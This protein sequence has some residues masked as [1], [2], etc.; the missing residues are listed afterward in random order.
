MT[1]DAV[2][3]SFTRRRELPLAICLLA[4]ACTQADGIGL[5]GAGA[6]DVAFRD[7]S[8]RIEMA[9]SA[10]VATP[11]NPVSDIS[12]SITTD[13][14]G[15]VYI[16]GTTDGALP[17]EDPVGLTDMFVRKYDPELD[18]LWT[19]Q[20]GTEFDDGTVTWMWAR[21][22][23]ATY[24]DLVYVSGSAP[25]GLGGMDAFLGA[26]DAVTGDEVW[27]RVFGS[28]AS[29]NALDI[30]ADEDGV[31]VLGW[32][33]QGAALPGPCLVDGEPGSADCTSSGST[34]IFL[35]AYDHQGGVKWTRQ[36]GTPG[37][38][39]RSAR[40]GGIT[41]HA[42]KIYLGG[43]LR[44]PDNK[45]DYALV[46]AF[47]TEDGLGWS[48]TFAAE[49]KNAAVLDVAADDT[50]VYFTGYDNAYGPDGFTGKYD[51]DG[52]R[53]WYREYGGSW[54]N[55]SAIAVRGPDVYVAGY[56]Y[57]SDSDGFLWRLD[58]ETGGE[59]DFDRHFVGPGNGLNE[60]A[61]GIALAGS[62]ILV[63]GTTESVLTPDAE[64]PGSNDVFVQTYTY[65]ATDFWVE[66]RTVQFGSTG[67]PMD[68]VRAVAFDGSA[69]FVAGNT[70]R[71]FPDAPAG[72]DAG[73]RDVF[74]QRY[75]HEGLLEWTRMYGED[76]ADLDFALVVTGD[77][78][79]LGGNLGDQEGFV[80][81]YGVDGSDGW[82]DTFPEDSYA[83]VYDAFADD[84]A[85]YLAG[86]GFGPSGST[87]EDFFL[88]KYDLDGNLDEGVSQ[89][90]GTS[91]R[92]GARAVFVRDDTIYLAGWTE[93]TLAGQASAGGRDAFL[94]A[95]DAGGTILWTRQFGTPDTD[96]ALGLYGD[97]SGVYVV[98][99]TIGALE[100]ENAGG[101]DAFIRKY[102]PNGDLLW[103]D[104]F[105]TT[106][107]ETAS[108]VA[109]ARGGVYVVGS[110]GGSLAGQTSLGGTD[111][112]LQK[113]TRAGLVEWTYQFGSAAYD[114]ADS[115]AVYAIDDDDRSGE[116]VEI[117]VGGVMSRDGLVAQILEWSD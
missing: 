64:T 49:I 52:Q 50:G 105:G 67:S 108:D 56:D 111:G 2:L 7:D 17:G 20:L 106:A 101:A 96:T 30:A 88:R 23:I 15:N 65:D 76:S 72:D 115:L 81:R 97:P 53:V 117:Y 4:S 100:G 10:I 42:G 66:Q 36:F 58:A 40:Y 34:D 18:V 70:E 94:R 48:D 98:G 95:Y 116:P 82:G 113:Y 69:L 68:S 12:G 37:A 29:E 84:T 77:A 19:T 91:M 51:L 75:T 13:T 83:V 107:D 86:M 47:D 26:Y 44:S 45:R 32:I 78:V 80:R 11:R 87:I 46:A 22:G 16:C 33:G 71:V 27:T 28:A 21:M 9:W 14:Q 62:D 5:P 43:T 39:M 31:Y 3:R 38:D 112:F 114:S 85:I 79:Y 41:V 92:D 24:G 104:Q 89:Y 109:T 54:A 35:R 74:A 93:G 110:T 25:T 63:I 55:G 8:R 99:A 90:D 102:K 73:G 60:R 61:N 103:T 57:T 1:S 59:G 6:T